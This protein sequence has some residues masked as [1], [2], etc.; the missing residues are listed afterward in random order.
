MSKVLSMKVCACSIRS[1]YNNIWWVFKI[2]NILP[3]FSNLMCLHFLGQFLTIKNNQ[4]QDSHGIGMP[5]VKKLV[6]LQN[7]TMDILSEIGKGTEV[8]LNFGY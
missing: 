2:L 3:I 7:G 6:E 1:S 8:V 4:T 5:L